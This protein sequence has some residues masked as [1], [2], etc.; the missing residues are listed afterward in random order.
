MKVLSSINWYYIIFNQKLPAELNTY[1]CRLIIK[2]HDFF[3]MSAVNINVNYKCD[4]LL[5]QL[6]GTFVEEKTKILSS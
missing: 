4:L 5:V 2:T 6:G 1:T 3:D